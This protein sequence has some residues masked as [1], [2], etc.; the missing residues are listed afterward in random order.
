M[1]THDTQFV[2]PHSGIIYT[3]PAA[4]D[5]VAVSLLLDEAVLGRDR[6]APLPSAWDAK[7]KAASFKPQASLKSFFAPKPK[8]STN[9]R[10]EPDTSKPSGGDN[11][12]PS[13]SG[14][15]ARKRPC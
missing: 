10:D 1:T 12:E 3:P 13:S 11:G 2:P 5:H 8:P 7:T 9:K 6:H 14:E 4:S 15:G